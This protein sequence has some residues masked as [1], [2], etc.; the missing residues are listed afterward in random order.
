MGKLFLQKKQW[1]RERK[2]AEYGFVCQMYT[3]VLRRWNPA[4]EAK[5]K[6]L[7]KT[8]KMYKEINKNYEKLSLLPK[9]KCAIIGAAKS[10]LK[11]ELSYGKGIAGRI[12]RK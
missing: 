2:T 10:T 3:S 11:G 6:N 4:Q 7:S 5:R 9:Q 8:G 1:K 12:I